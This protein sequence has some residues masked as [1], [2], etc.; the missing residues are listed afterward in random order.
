VARD[1]GRDDD[2]MA[3]TTALLIMDVQGG[4]VDRYPEAAEPLLGRLVDAASA[5][6]DAGVRVVYVRVAFREGAPEVSPRNRMFAILASS[7][8]RFGDDD[9]STQIHPA[10]AP[11]PGDIVVTKRRVSAFA[12]SD[13][14]Y[15][16]VVL[17]NGCLDGDEEVHRILCDK[18][19]PRQAEVIDVAAWV[20][21]L[22]GPTPR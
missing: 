4:V 21:S 12:G 17:R 11:L 18:V 10:V 7:G 15:E 20:A 16:L 1:D 22:P 14:D 19:F 13:L 9:A 2:G 6:R 8:R 3:M 5:A